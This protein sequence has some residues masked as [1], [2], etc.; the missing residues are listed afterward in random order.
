MHNTWTDQHGIA[1][2]TESGRTLCGVPVEPTS[3]VAV[4]GCAGCVRESIRDYARRHDCKVSCRPHP[5]DQRN[6]G[7]HL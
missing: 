7:A 6:P 1:H 2:F 3:T 5:L 4:H